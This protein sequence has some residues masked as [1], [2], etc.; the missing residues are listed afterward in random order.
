MDVTGRTGPARVGVV[1]GN[2]KVRGRGEG[3]S[4]G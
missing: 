1:V 4:R 3:M 2:R